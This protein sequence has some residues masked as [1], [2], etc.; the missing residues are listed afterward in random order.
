M[1]RPDE[2][3]LIDFGGP[4]ER[5]ALAVGFSPKHVKTRTYWNPGRRGLE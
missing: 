3:V 1:T 4:A 5:T 2:H